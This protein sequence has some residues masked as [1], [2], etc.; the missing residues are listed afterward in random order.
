M[1][2]TI[3]LNDNY[4]K[5]LRDEIMGDP[6]NSLTGE[7]EI[8]VKNRKTGEIESQQKHNLIVYGGR[9]WLLKK[10]FCT[11]VAE[12]P[13]FIRNSEIL[14]FGVGNG[15]GEPG[16]PLQCGCTYGSDNDL[17]NPV[18]LRYEFNTNEQSVNPYYASRIMANGD[19]VNGFY[20]KITYVSVKPDQ[21]N[22]YKVGNKVTYPNLIAE[23]R[24]EITPD[25]GTGQTFLN[26]DY[27]KGYC[28][29]NEAA[30][31]IADSRLMDPGQQDKTL[32]YY[33]QDY[34][35]YNDNRKYFLP[36]QNLPEYII[37][38]IDT[39]N[40]K[41]EWTSDK[42]F[43]DSLT[44]YFD[45][46]FEDTKLNTQPLLFGIY[47]DGSSSLTGSIRL[48]AQQHKLYFQ[49]ITP[50]S[51]ECSF[52]LDNIPSDVTHIDQL[53]FKST[54]TISIK[55]EKT[56]KIED[57]SKIQTKCQ[58]RDG[59]TTDYKDITGY[60]YLFNDDS[61]IYY[62]LPVGYV[63]NQS[64]QKWQID[65]NFIFQSII[66]VI[67][68]TDLSDE[69]VIN[70]IVTDQHTLQCRC[71]VDNETI[72]KLQEGMKVY[73]YDDSE[74]SN[75]IPYETPATITDI[76]NA[77]NVINPDTTIKSYFVIEHD[78]FK[79]EVYPQGLKCKFYK[80]T[81]DNPYIMFNRVTFSTIRMSKSRDIVLIWRIYF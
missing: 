35:T 55:V 62:F 45:I 7:V 40:S 33:T 37:K 18:R 32:T 80:T 66:R 56:D 29:I 47:K 75:K 53:T 63:Y 70:E 49:F 17:Y 22:P 11:N 50:D 25:D 30:L 28:D 72:E 2:K 54:G 41:I 79:S 3:I 15:G 10:S 34:T 59:Y 24:M 1:N 51:N 77:K 4:G 6:N 38:D 74:S 71:Y 57:Q 13:S 58:Y 23:L 46:Y 60:E 73:T 5:R 42:P 81:K 21:A 14:W 61:V 65:H 69:L 12:N 20:K 26:N 76:Y 19:V 9:E 68:A 52:E 27:E 36:E 8:Q 43:P 67:Q 44:Q 39:F 78:G 48:N 64:E 16:N 31:F